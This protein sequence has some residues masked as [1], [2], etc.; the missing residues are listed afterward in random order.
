MT[1]LEFARLK[2]QRK[3]TKCQIFHSFGAG[4][5]NAFV[6]S[7]K[8]RLFPK[9]KIG[10]HITLYHAA[11]IIGH[12]LIEETPDGNIAN[13]VVANFAAELRQAER[14]Y[15]RLVC[16]S[17]GHMIFLLAVQCLME[18]VSFTA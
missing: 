3:E 17:C 11:E 18:A 1:I 16:R 8:N 6:M 7:W 9:K 10:N 2:L 12:K 15:K 5:L 13:N 14:L 4:P